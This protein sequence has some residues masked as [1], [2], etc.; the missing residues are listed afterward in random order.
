MF[1]KL[2]LTILFAVFGVFIWA[3]ATQA[4][5][6][7]S[8]PYVRTNKIIPG[9]HFEQ[10]INLLRSSAEEDLQAI[11]TINAPD[12]ES[13]I[14]IDKGTKFD[15]PQDELRVPMIVN[16]DVPNN[17]PL[18]TY[19]GNINIRIAPDEDRQGG[20][21][22]IALGARVDIDLTVTDETF[23]DFLVRVV[24]IPRIEMLGKPWNWPI[25]SWFF[26]RI[27][28]M[29]K[30]E[31]TGN[32]KIAPTRVH[33]DVYDIL[34]KKLLESHDDRRMEKVEPFAIKEIKAT[35]PTKLGEGGYWGKVKVYKGNSV[36]RNDKISFTIGPK[37]AYGNGIKKYGKWPWLMLSGLIALCLAIIFSLVKI[38][39]WRY[40]FKILYILSWP[41]RYS[42]KKFIALLR[43]LKLKFW[44]RLH[45]ISAKYQKSDNKDKTV[46]AKKLDEEKQKKLEE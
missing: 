27:E 36:V 20:G 10:R 32:V 26:Y 33:I 12:I 44:Q 23:P 43:V 22:A 6:G 9:S 38:K 2:L 46:D 7:I 3:T 29:M 39:I 11:I 16:V 41:I 25:F 28:V 15:L 37:G 35:F 14:T 13:W 21:V 18:G 42:F 5:F 19:K 31:N 17:A 30:V 34:E 24:T 8:P 4:G 45:K 40:I 1:K